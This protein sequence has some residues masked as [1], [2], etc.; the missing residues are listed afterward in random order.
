MNMKDI[1]EMARNLNIRNSGRIKKA[2][3]IHQIQVKEGNTPCFG[4]AHQGDCDQ[5]ECL[6]YEDCMK[7][8]RG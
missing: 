7:Q 5:K 4:T 2:D 6:W 1:R 3:L 8:S